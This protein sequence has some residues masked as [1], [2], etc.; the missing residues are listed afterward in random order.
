M[1]I[2]KGWNGRERRESQCSHASYNDK[3]DRLHLVWLFEGERKSGEVQ[4]TDEKISSSEGNA[5]L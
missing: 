2:G 4:G 1:W 5:N 3:H